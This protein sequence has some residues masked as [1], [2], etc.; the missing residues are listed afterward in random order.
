MIL[1]TGANGKLGGATIDFLLKKNPF[2]TIAGLVRDRGKGEAL[3]QKGARIRIGD[4]FDYNSL[5]EAF[6][7]VD[8]LVFISSG[9]VARRVEQHQHV[10]NAARENGVKHI[11][12]TS[13]LGVSEKTSGIFNDHF[14]TEKDITASGISYT[15]FRN[16]F[17]TDVLPM[18]LG[19]ALQSG[20]LYYPSGNA[21]INIAARVDM[22]EAMA[23]VVLNPE[24]HINKV[25]EITSANAYSFDD[26]AR[27]LG[28]AAGKQVTYTEISFEQLKEGLKHTG[29]PEGMIGMIANISKMI[30][31]RYLDHTDPVL[32][33]L[34]QRKPVDLKEVIDQYVSSQG[35]KK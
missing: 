33:N 20:H 7:R 28:E 35:A 21:K 27:M 25:Y 30:S 9:T 11:L 3:Q 34:L 1:V 23:N 17:Y 5:Q 10:V 14:I 13:F 15:I 8:T 19:D 18:L 16:T 4:Y 31:N 32:E 29:L 6:K 2:A 26:I 24:L 22:A 12:Y